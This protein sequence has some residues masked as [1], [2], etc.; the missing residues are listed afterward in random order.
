MAP[1]T[2]TRVG[3][4]AGRRPRPL[5]ILR[6]RAIWGSRVRQIVVGHRA[7]DAFL[8]GRRASWNSRAADSG[9]IRFY[10]A[11]RLSRQL[12]CGGLLPAGRRGAGPTVKPAHTRHRGSLPGVL[13]AMVRASLARTRACV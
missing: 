12:E 6:T 1:G 3:T 2:G 13:L 7:I 11:R 8:R 5:S 4:Y 10:L 9:R